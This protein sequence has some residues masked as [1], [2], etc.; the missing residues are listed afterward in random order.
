VG[1]Y[2]KKPQPTGVTK[3]VGVA[4]DAAAVGVALGRSPGPTIA[5]GLGT[6]VRARARVTPANPEKSARIRTAKAGRADTTHPLNAG[7]IAWQCD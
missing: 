1:V 3:G 7:I 2:A 4:V 5:V 6:G